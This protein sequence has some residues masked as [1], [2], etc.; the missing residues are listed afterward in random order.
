MKKEVFIRLWPKQEES[1]MKILKRVSICLLAAAMALTMLTACDGG[2]EENSTPEQPA[3]STGG[4]NA[5]SEAPSQPAPTPPSSESASTPASSE[6]AK[7]ALPTT[8]AETRTNAYF[9]QLGV[10]ASNVYEEYS[11]IVESE[12]GT[13]KAAAK[14]GRLYWEGTTTSE[15]QHIACYTD[16]KGNAYNIDFERRAIK[17]YNAGTREAESIQI[18]TKQMIE[19]YI[20]IP[21]AAD[22]ATVSATETYQYENKNYYAETI[23]IRVKVDDQ[24]YTGAWDYLFDGDQLKYVVLPEGF[25]GT[26][27]KVGKIEANP[28]ESVFALPDWYSTNYES[29]RTSAYFKS[30]GVSKDRYFVKLTLKNQGNPEQKVIATV[31]G[32]RAYAGRSNWWGPDE[33][34]EGHL[35][36]G[37][38]SDYYR[39]DYRNKVYYGPQTI[40]KAQY[41]AYFT[42]GECFIIPDASNTLYMTCG[43]EQD[44]TKSYYKENFYIK[45]NEATYLYSY[46]FDG[47]KL[48]YIKIGEGSYNYTIVTIDS[49]SSVP[50]ENLLKIPDG[51][52]N[53]MQQE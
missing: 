13:F 42:A 51:F 50:D 33:I 46:Y 48:A 21:A 44:G 23:K 5:D 37:G 28:A 41:D 25:G 26:I 11:G 35:I 16:E 17:K 18:L 27:I 9:S 52:K 49:I 22:V 19:L 14:G 38:T 10:T 20:P 6:P 39:I 24:T 36:L 12:S 2:G 4:E 53:G 47:N 1:A 43:T 31:N 3:T 30:Q 29:S 45:I 40:E 7:P 32:N 8:W 34:T 15:Q